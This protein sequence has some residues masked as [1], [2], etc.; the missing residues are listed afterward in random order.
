MVKKIIQIGDKKL[1]EQSEPVEL[2]KIGSGETKK[3]ITDIID[4]CKFYYKQAAGLSAVQI[5]VLKQIYVVKRVDLEDDNSEETNENWDA[6]I[7]PR[8]VYK[9][10]EQSVEWEG[11]MSINVGK[12]KLF[13]PVYRSKIVEIEYYT[14]EG[15][16]KTLRG[17]K[18]FSHLIQHEQD[19]LEG[20]LFLNYIKNP[21]NIWNEE[22]LDK[23]LKQFKEFP[24][25]E[26]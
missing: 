7:N 22:E 12:N 14:P 15:E 9:S 3:L 13:G 6:I 21:K 19:H 20:K 10:E 16:K 2:N 1:L 24:P 11:C 26:E 17:K 18:F 5:G 4:T 8:I 25:I 23:Y